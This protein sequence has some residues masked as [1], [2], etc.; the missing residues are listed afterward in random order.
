MEGDGKMEIKIIKVLERFLIAIN[1]FCIKSIVYL[2][3]RKTNKYWANQYLE[4]P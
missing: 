3:R 4:K 1:G 2:R